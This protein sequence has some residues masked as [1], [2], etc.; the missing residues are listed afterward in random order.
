MC[1]WTLTDGTSVELECGFVEVPA[2]HLDPDTGSIN[3]AVNVHRATSSDKRIGYLLINPGGPGQ[4]G[5][6]FVVGTPLSDEITERF[7]IVGFDPRGV[8]WSEPK[9]ACGEPSEQLALR[10]SVSADGIIDTP[11]EI[12]AGE[13]AANLC[14]ESMGPVGSLLNSAY[15]ALDM[16]GIREALGAEQISY[17]GGSYGSALGAWYATLFPE[18]V[19]AVVV[20]GASNPV[21]ET[22]TLEERVD[23]YIELLAVREE[24]WERALLACDDPTCPI[25]NDS[26]PIG[27]YIEAAEKLGLVNDAAGGYPLAG[28]LGVFSTLY[29]EA[30]WPT[31]WQGL[32]ELNEND[33]PTILLDS[34][35]IQFVGGDPT[36]PSFAEH[37]NCLDRWLLPPALDRAARL[38]ESA[39]TATEG[40]FPLQDAGGGAYLDHCPFYDQFTID[41]LKVPLD[42]GG[43]PILVIGNREDPATPFV[44]SEAFA[45]ETLSNGYLVETSHATHVVYPNNECVNGH[46]HR[47]LI[48]GVYPSERRVFCEREDPEPA[49]T[50]SADG[51]EAESLCEIAAFECSLVEVPADYRDP[52]AGSI[53][54]AFKVYSAT[55][56]DERIGYL[57]VNP[58]GTS[59]SGVEKALTAEFGTFTDEILDRFDIVGFDPRGVGS[60]EP[61]FACGAPG[62]QLRLRAS[63]EDGV[64]DTPE[65]IAAMEA[66]ANLCIESMGP[67]GGLLHT[68]YVARDMDKIRKAL[69]AEQ[70][71]YLG[72][73]YGSTLGAWYA[74]LFPESVRAM[75]VDGVNNPVD[76]AAT[77]EERIGEAIEEAGPI[78]AFLGLALSACNSPECPI[79]NDGDPIGYYMEAAAKLD[80]VNSAAGGYPLAGYLGVVLAGL[81]AFQAA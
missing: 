29:A 13:A 51:T 30:S 28:Y 22:T 1:S 60:S 39:A 58:G 14:I 43:V 7:D 80:L 5:L 12:A 26:D 17:W 20:D 74:T 10:A 54:I 48:D 3:I 38:E 25:Y 68:D 6:E 24:Q 63:V 31:L 46:V 50:L 42:G 21:E 19:R 61:D 15:V 71:S 75:V 62:E 59:R 57:F 33:D 70:I 73:D 8:G 79:Y 81:Y 34:A 41:P 52:E 37:V 27:Y 44:K 40:M 56:P 32:F 4:S 11:E 53:S 16:H 66:A 47:A 76:A 18:R 9:F 23:K 69:G 65:E 49:P 77:M 78:G 67:I 2:D 55:S 45:T 36:V 72:A 64:P 35:R